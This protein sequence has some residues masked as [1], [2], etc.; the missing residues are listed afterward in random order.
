MLDE[1][2]VM[3][4]DVVRKTFTMIHNLN[5]I[6]ITENESE[7]QIP[8]DPITTM[9]RIKAIRQWCLKMH[10]W[11][12]DECFRQS[13]LSTKT[14]I[15]VFSGEWTSWMVGLAPKW[16]RL[17]PNGTNS[18]LFQIRFQCIWRPQMGQIRGFF[19]SDFSTF[20]AGAPNALKSDLKKPRI[21]PIWGQSEP[22]WSQ[23]YHPCVRPSLSPHNTATNTT[24]KCLYAWRIGLVWPHLTFCLTP[25]QRSAWGDIVH[26]FMDTSMSTGAHI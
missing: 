19:R 11:T 20:G 6:S 24:H 8:F 10:T 5:I 18:G 16:V 3:R 26:H 15:S 7:N 21:C 2:T 4:H 25:G 1:S 22:L 23:T 13:F 12:C 9:W 14:C 17:A